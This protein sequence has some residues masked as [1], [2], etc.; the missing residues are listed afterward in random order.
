LSRSASLSGEPR[1][2]LLRQ[3]Q[4][5]AAAATPYLPVWLVA[6]R[7]WAQRSLKPPTFDGSGRLVLQALQRSPQP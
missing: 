7:A 4:R 5:R 3:I 1:R 6:P 2:Q